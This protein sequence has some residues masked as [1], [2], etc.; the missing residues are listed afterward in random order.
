MQIIPSSLLFL[1]ALLILPE[2][3]RFLLQKNQPIKAR[4]ILSY[5]RK[6]DPEHVYISAEMAEIEEAISRQRG[7]SEGRE[8]GKGRLA[9]FAGLWGELWWKGNRNRIC[10]GVGL[11]AGQNLTGINGVNFFTPMVFRS[12]GFGGTR[13]TLLAS[14]LFTFLSP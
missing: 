3:P 7:E 9:R 5:I 6:L 8:R 12:I 14:G 2:S 4:Q 10:I 11:M 1:S 13:V